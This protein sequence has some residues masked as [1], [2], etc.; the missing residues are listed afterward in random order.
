MTSCTFFVQRLNELKGHSGKLKGLERANPSHT[1]SA[2]D[3]S[4]TDELTI[5]LTVDWWK[6]E[7]L[8]EMIPSDFADC[9]FFCE[10]P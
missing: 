7:L 6:T 5:K 9:V 3:C 4:E 2:W 1:G 10:I 8:K